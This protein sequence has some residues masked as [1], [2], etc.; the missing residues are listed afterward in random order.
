MRRQDRRTDL[1]PMK[2]QT[3]AEITIIRVARKIAG[4]LALVSFAL[5]A[6]MRLAAVVGPQTVAP[7]QAAAPAPQSAVSVEFAAGGNVSQV[8]IEVADHLVMIPISVNGKQPSWFLV[9][10]ESPKS[11]FDDV[12]A[13][14]LELDNSANGPESK[15]IANATLDFPSLKIHVSSLALEPL[16]DLGSRIGHTVQGILGADVLSQ[17]VMEINY[18]RQMIQFFDPKSYSYSGKGEK[19]KLQPV[20]DWSTVEAKISLHNRGTMHVL[21]R[22]ATGQSM[23]ISFSPR[24]AVA[25]QFSELGM[26]MIPYMPLQASEAADD[27][28]GRI[29]SLVIGKLEVQDPLAVFPGKSARSENAAEQSPIEVAGSLGGEVLSR[30]TLILNSPANQL[31]LEPGLHLNDLFTADMSGMEITAIPPDFH[32]FEIAAVFPNSPAAAAGLAV[33]D[34]LYTI[35]DRNASDY[36]LDDVRAIFRQADIEHQITVQRG[37]K[38]LQFTLKLKP[39]V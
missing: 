30:F 6:P 16:S 12:Q 14:A 8:P 4:F 34:I 2:L 31:I 23:G 19:F 25:H 32:D 10:T 26:P 17:I 20:G 18:D 36:T 5:L 11:W 9:D 35:D 22:I 28:L 29:E 15:S 33:G 7:P 37:G 3:H 38:T 27:H 21:F 13:A 1:H 24:F 39:L